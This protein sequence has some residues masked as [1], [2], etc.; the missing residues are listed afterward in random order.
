LTPALDESTT[1]AP[2]TA[3]H[4]DADHCITPQDG[5]GL[6]RVDGEKLVEL[7]IRKN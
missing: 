2:E 1:H 3:P 4:F 7:H 6:I 5:T